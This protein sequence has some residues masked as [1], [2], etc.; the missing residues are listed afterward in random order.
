MPEAATILAV[1]DK[2]LSAIGLAREGKRAKEQRR[3]DALNALYAA[4]NETQLYI[5]ERREGKKRNRRREFQIARLWSDAATAV[6]PLDHRLARICHCKR[7]YWCE[8]DLWDD[9]RIARNGIKIE[10]VQRKIRRL[11][12][13]H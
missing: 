13:A 1:A 12:L 2:V 3:R 8:A 9:A 10:T 7:T 11:L 6:S 5:S 4:I